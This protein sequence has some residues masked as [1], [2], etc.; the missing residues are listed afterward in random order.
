MDSAHIK[1][2]KL[3]SMIGNL[4]DLAVA[5]S[6]GMDSMFLLA[7]A[8]EVLGD[9]VI[10]VTA[11]SPVSTEREI[12]EA[13]E[14][15]TRSGIRLIKTEVDLLGMDKFINNP[16]DRCYHCKRE[17]FSKIIEVSSKEGFSCVADGTNTDDDNDYRPGMRALKELGVLSPLR[18]A[19]FSKQEIF[20]L[21]GE[22]GIPA[23]NKPASAC[24]ASRIPYGEAITADKLK[25]IGEAEEYLRNLGFTQVRVRHHGEIARI[26]VLPDE[27]NRFADKNLRN[28]I[29]VK[30][31]ELGFKFVVLELEGYKKGS[32]NP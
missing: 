25:I 31:K 13:A 18:E 16:P 17:I 3:K 9:R 24:L 15:T 21:A 28:T 7:V 4:N 19:G 11:V 14:Y 12:C 29:S 1:L 5:Y 27:I 8:H 22:M 26:E 30:L 23:K 20:N 10:A 32:L 6:G 2:E